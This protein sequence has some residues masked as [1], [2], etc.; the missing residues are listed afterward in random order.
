MIIDDIDEGNST[1]TVLLVLVIWSLWSAAIPHGL[2]RR[3]CHLF[4]ACLE[5][6]SIDN[7]WAFRAGDIFRSWQAA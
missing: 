6:W 1:N 2:S 4:E 3:P 7:A 5:H